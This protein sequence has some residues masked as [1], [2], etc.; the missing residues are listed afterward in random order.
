[1]SAKSLAR[2]MSEQEEAVD[3]LYVSDS[4]IVRVQQIRE[5]TNSK[6][7]LLSGKEAPAYRVESYD[8]GKI[9]C[10][11]SPPPKV[12]ALA[13]HI[14]KERVKIGLV[15]VIMLIAVGLFSFTSEEHESLDLYAVSNTVAVISF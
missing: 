2:Y 6:S 5:S 10:W 7:S 13:K 9:L 1:M 11:K 12:Y 14:T 3:P 4:S 15:L 8:T